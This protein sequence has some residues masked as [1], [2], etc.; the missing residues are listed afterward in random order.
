MDSRTETRRN[1]YL[2]GVAWLLWSEYWSGKN[3][4]IPPL[5]M[6]RNGANN[7]VFIATGATKSDVDGFVNRHFNHPDYMI[8]ATG[9]WM[10]NPYEWIGHWHCFFINPRSKSVLSG[11]V[12]L[13]LIQEE[14]FPD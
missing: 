8:R 14:E 3:Q 7:E 12:D 13:R 5:T 9:D 10:L 1:H 4:L 11:K 2:T 6:L